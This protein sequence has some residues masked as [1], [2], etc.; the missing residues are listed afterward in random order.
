MAE[1][2]GL[3]TKHRIIN[4]SAQLERAAK[5]GAYGALREW[6]RRESGGGE[7]LRRF[8]IV[9][10]RYGGSL[11]IC[12][13]DSEQAARCAAGKEV[14]GLTKGKWLSWADEAIDYMVRTSR[15]PSDP[16]VRAKVEAW[17]RDA[18]DDPEKATVARLLVA[19]ASKCLT[20]PQPR[21]LLRQD[22]QPRQSYASA[23]ATAASPPRQAELQFAAMMH[24]LRRE[25]EQGEAAL[26][27][28]IEATMS[29]Q[30]EELE[31]RTRL[32]REENE[33]QVA[34]MRSELTAQATR[35]SGVE[36]VVA[37]LHEMSGTIT[38]R[39]REELAPDFGA[40][41]AQLNQLTRLMLRAGKENTAPQPTVF[42]LRVQQ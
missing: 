39:V 40:L 13:W 8:S 27:A 6:V 9:R 1:T 30:C 19:A 23:V 35:V 24:Q 31:R 29:R 18:G 20:A 11:I 37:E 17:A 15:V 41:T 33:R 42:G 38:H 21:P 32:W 14:P 5:L 7:V 28:S 10:D 25:R 2:W 26:R 22:A 4:G 36:A 3:N 16:G 34:E 12:T